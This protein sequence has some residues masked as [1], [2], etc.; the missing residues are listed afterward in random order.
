MA[1]LRMTKSRGYWFQRMVQIT[2]GAPIKVPFFTLPGMPFLLRRIR[3]VQADVEAVAT[4]GG[5]TQTGTHTP[6]LD[7][8][9]GFLDLTDQNSLYWAA[10]GDPWDCVATKSGVPYPLGNP[11]V[12]PATVTAGE[13]YHF[14]GNHTISVAY[15]PAAGNI[16]KATNTDANIGVTHGNGQTAYYVYNAEGSKLVSIPRIKASLYIASGNVKVWPEAPV[17]A[18]LSNLRQT[19][20]GIQRIFQPQPAD[21]QNY[22]VGW[23]GSAPG[24]NYPVNYK[25][26]ANAQILVELTGQAVVPALIGATG[27]ND[28]GIRPD[29]VEI[30]LEGYN[31]DDGAA[32]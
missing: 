26:A 12:L 17:D 7:T 25:Y 5:W 16:I 18:L 6:L 27:P 23:Q 11:W 3:V 31:I 2:G 22:G 13:I 20:D 21:M 8:V 29:Y 14:D 32:A 9:L 10:Y 28:T 24:D 15:V 4:P 1:D 19:A 30:T